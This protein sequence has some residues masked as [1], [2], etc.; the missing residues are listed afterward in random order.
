MVSRSGCV[1]ISQKKGGGAKWWGES[2]NFRP[3]RKCKIHHCD[4]PRREDIALRKFK[5]H[6]ATLGNARTIR[7]GA[8]TQGQPEFMHEALCFFRFVLQNTNNKIRAT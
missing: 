7:S 2:C 1:S 3:V 5:M 6:A 8:S 4:Q